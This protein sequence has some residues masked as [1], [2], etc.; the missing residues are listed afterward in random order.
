MAADVEVAHYF[1]I[2]LIHLRGLFLQEVKLLRSRDI[3][4]IRGIYHNKPQD[5]IQFMKSEPHLSDWSKKCARQRIMCSRM[6]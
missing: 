1:S 4:F 3:F 2:C 5:F 6:P